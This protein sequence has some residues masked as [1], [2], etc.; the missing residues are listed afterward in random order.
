MK[1]TKDSK[2]HVYLHEIK[3]VYNTI[4]SIN[5]PWRVSVVLP[6]NPCSKEFDIKYLI[7]HRFS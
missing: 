3:Q 7:G 6:T 5:V 2:L 1:Y 4:E